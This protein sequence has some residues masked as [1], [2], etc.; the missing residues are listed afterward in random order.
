MPSVRLRNIAGIAPRLASDDARMQP[1]N[2]RDR[3]GRMYVRV[4]EGGYV[5]DDEKVVA[6]PSAQAAATG[7]QWG[8]G[9]SAPCGLVMHDKGAGALVLDPQTESPTT[10]V[11]GL[12]N[13]DVAFVEHQGFV[14]WTDGTSIGRIDASG[15]PRPGTI[16]PTSAPSVATTGGTMPAG[17]YLVGYTWIDS[18]GMKGPC[19]ALTKIELVATGGFSVSVAAFPADAA[20]ARVYCSAANGSEPRLVGTYEV[21]AFPLTITTEPTSKTVLRTLGLSPLPP[22]GGLTTRGGFLLSWSGT[23]LSHSRGDFTALTNLDID[24]HQFPSTILGAVG[25]EEGVW[26]VTEDGLYW[27]R[28]RDL[29]QAAIQRNQDQRVYAKGGWLLPPQYAGIETSWPAA[30]FVSDEGPVYCSSDGRVSA[31][32]A[33][34]QKWDVAGKT[35]SLALWEQGGTKLVAIEVSD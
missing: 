28:G 14:W 25:V 34:T 8:N 7:A 15:T 19:A 2:P 35:A 10:L 9:I 6:L 30:V 31:P 13:A 4:L 29:G 12:A 32:L 3:D 5:T 23:E 22:G 18:S 24:Y 1:P 16:Q 11:S 27:L 21:S 20:S 26:V 33:S 17:D